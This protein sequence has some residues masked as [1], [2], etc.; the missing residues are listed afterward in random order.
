MYAGFVTTGRVVKSIGIHQRFD[1]AAYNMVSQYFK[2][3]TFPGIGEILHFE[4]INGPDGVKVKSLGVQDPSHMYDPI[5]DVGVLPD[6][7][8]NHYALLVE[9]LQE[10]DL[11]RAAFEASWLAHYV[12][13][14]L[15][16]AHHYPYDEKK[17]ELFG[18]ASQYNLLHKGW[19]WLGGKGVLSTHLNFEMGVAST[20][21]LF[22]LK[23]KLDDEKLAEARR[24][25]MV[26][27][28]KQEARQVAELKLYDQF[29]EKGWTAE[30]ARTI[31]QQ[32]APHAV[33]VVGIIWL[34][35]YLEAGQ[36]E[37]TTGQVLPL[38][39]VA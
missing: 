17:A 36:A 31:K 21:L 30:L 19:L 25:G 12:T 23:V 16:P 37:L 7:I 14:G 10:Q 11:V 26:P 1:A 22:P 15:T 35:A 9:S 24:M 18:E 13:D 32:I 2:P 28:F 33:Q 29:Y 4:G 39:K 20:L 27:F 38:N 34:L 8:T 5:S 6:L 3:G